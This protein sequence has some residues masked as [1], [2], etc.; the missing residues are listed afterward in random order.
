MLISK[1][2]TFYKRDDI[3]DEIVRHAADKEIAVRYEDSFG[4]RPD[5]ISYSGD[6]LEF[7]KRRA[8]SFHCSEELW[9][10]PNELRPAM[11]REEL[12][13][14]RIGWDMILDID[15]ED[16]FF[17]RLTA[18]LFVKALK[19]HGIV[20]IGCKF[21]GNKGFH[22]GVPFQAFPK[23]IAYEGRITDTKDLFPEATKRIAQYLLNFVSDKYIVVD[24]ENQTIVFDKKHSFQ[25]RELEKRFLKKF[26]ELT[27]RKCSKCG[28]EVKGTVRESQEFIC[29]T[30]GKTIV[31]NEDYLK[32]PKCSRLMQRVISKEPLCK[33]GSFQA[34]PPK[35]NPLSIM[36]FD[37]LL[38]SSRH[39]YRMPY[40]FNEKSGLISIP[41]VAE[42]IMDFEKKDAMP[43]NIVTA[44]SYLN[45]DAVKENEASALIRDAFDY[46]PMIEGETEEKKNKEYAMPEE[47]IPEKF[48]PPCIL[49]I[50]KGME[51]GRKRSLFILQNFLSC[52]GWNPGQTET[53]MKEWN[54]KNPEPLREVNIV[55]QLRY[56]KQRKEKILPPNCRAYYQDLGVC[57]PDSICDR[58]KN[59]VQYAKKR[60]FRPKK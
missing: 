46:N 23:Q 57:S 59:P 24:A 31:C 1:T 36:Q 17:A 32:C 44:H 7:A 8:T 48:F 14:L 39:M 60:S 12:D 54:K 15:C 21:S 55:G 41:V 2:L 42:R 45:R 49:N 10:N 47:A 4:K 35:F 53:L 28:R 29:E 26:N 34:S 20:S 50:L 25:L 6:V 56:H 9:S 38:I 22:I 58:I 52:C 18:H 3:R 27:I 40:S 37:S 13:S 19:E 43:E 5:V 33:C 11:K 51:D 30:C 16:W